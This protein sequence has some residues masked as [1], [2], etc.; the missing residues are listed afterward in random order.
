MSTL[1]NVKGDKA[2]IEKPCRWGH[3]PSNHADFAMKLTKHGMV[4]F[5]KCPC[6]SNLAFGNFEHAVRYIYEWYEDNNPSNTYED[7]RY[8]LKIVDLSANQRRAERDETLDSNQIVLDF[9]AGKI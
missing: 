5:E 9:I 8:T 2:W 3:E 7:F 6:G 1:I 4:V